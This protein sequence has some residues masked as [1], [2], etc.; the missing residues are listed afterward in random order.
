MTLGTECDVPDHRIMTTTHI[1]DAEIKARVELELH[2]APELDTTHIGLAV[3]DGSVTLSGE[4]ADFS[5]IEIAERAAWKVS[6]VSA[7]AREMNV[8]NE[9]GPVNDTDIARDVATELDR[10]SDVPTDSVH[11][12]VTH[13]CVFLTGIV[14]WDFQRAAAESSAAN[15]HGVRKVSNMIEVSP[16]A[17]AEHVARHVEAVL[18]HAARVAA[19]HISISTDGGGNVIL[20]GTAR[21]I[22]ESDEICRAAREARGV[23]TVQNRLHVID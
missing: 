15:V 23:E 19:Q 1:S 13:G 17:A 16:R 7:V 6:G 10:N 22:A 8:R 21:S 20:E 4:V 5:Q 11:T 12:T 2:W 3:T 18:E 14:L 9:A